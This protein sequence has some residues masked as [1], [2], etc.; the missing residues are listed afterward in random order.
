MT[1]L[2]LERVTFRYPATE[3]PA[4]EDVSLEV[5]GGE[6]VALVGSV[7][8]GAS[9]LLLVAGDLAPRVVGGRLEGRVSFDGDGPRAIVLPT[10]WTQLSG[11]GFT[12]EEEVAFGPANLGRSRERI[13][14]KAAPSRESLVTTSGQRDQASEDRVRNPN[15]DVAAA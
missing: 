1:R 9:T 6:V 14:I 4:L 7:G 10:P 3:A 2:I 12:V 5:K 8:A 15:P 11:L 13:A